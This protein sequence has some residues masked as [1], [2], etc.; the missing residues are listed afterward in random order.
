MS[1]VRLNHDEIKIESLTKSQISGSKPKLGDIPDEVLWNVFSFLDNSSTVPLLLTNTTFYGVK[2]DQEKHKQH[3]L[4]TDLKNSLLPI[5][6]KGCTGF[7]NIDKI[8]K[9][10]SLM[11]IQ[12]NLLL[13]KKDLISSLKE[14][15]RRVLLEV[16][17]CC[18]ENATPIGFRNFERL[19]EIY[20]SYDEANLRSDLYGEEN[21]PD[22]NDDRDPGSLYPKSTLLRTVVE[23]LVNICEIEEALKIAYEIPHA[24]FKSAALWLVADGLIKQN[25][26][27]ECWEVIKTIPDKEK[28]T[29]ALGSVTQTLEAQGKLEEWNKIKANLA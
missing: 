3:E 4:I 21:E 11:D 13:I 27:E 10:I 19:S 5:L 26:L 24:R 28:Q 12:K 16:D 29:R 15:D 1:F 25:K 2:I 20:K 9:S 8:L 6:V 14:V 23:E 7:D 18:I 17:E 22:C